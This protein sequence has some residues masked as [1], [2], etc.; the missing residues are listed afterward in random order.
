M[1]HMSDALSVVDRQE[2]AG[3]LDELTHIKST[4]RATLYAYA[5]QWQAVWVLTFFGAGLVAVVPEWRHIAGIY[6]AFATPVSVMSTILISVKVESRS[7][8]RQ[9]P[10]PYIVVGLAITAGTSLTSLLLPEGAIVVVVWVVV[11]FGFAAFAWLERVVPAA[12]LL[13]SMSVIAGILGLVVEDSFQLYPAIAFAYSAALA[14]IVIGM[15]I[16]AKR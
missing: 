8:L 2:A 7:P 12:Y 11:G 6:W 10:L 14:G 4:T 5:W 3:L 15:R 1:E 13:A 16:Q 9:R